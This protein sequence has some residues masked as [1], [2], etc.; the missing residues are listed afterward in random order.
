MASLIE[1]RTLTPVN[2]TAPTPGPGTSNSLSVSETT[3]PDYVSCVRR[4]TVTTTI[5]LQNSFSVI[6]GYGG[7]GGYRTRSM[8]E[9]LNRVP[10]HYITNV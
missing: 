3:C 9:S 7:C 2:L 8:T 6:K 10:I 4:F 1:L 5:E